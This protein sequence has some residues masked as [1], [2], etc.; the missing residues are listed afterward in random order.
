MFQALTAQVA[1][2]VS[3]LYPHAYFQDACSNVV[4]S[5]TSSLYQIVLEMAKVILPVPPLLMDSHLLEII[6]STLVINYLL[7]DIVCNTSEWD[8][9]WKIDSCQT[10]TVIKRRPA[11]AVSDAPV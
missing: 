9:Q 5:E 11:Q 7:D 2:A 4:I 8:M 10:T 1:W 6:S 3:L